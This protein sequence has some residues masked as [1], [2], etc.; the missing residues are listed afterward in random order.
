M[1]KK[2]KCEIGINDYNEPF[3]NAT[4]NGYQ[5]KSITVNT[6]EQLK[7]ICDSLKAFLKASRKT[8]TN[9]A[10]TRSKPTGLR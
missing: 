10:Q 7:S 2:F 1:K 3:I 4:R 6:I 8:S 9:K 5:W